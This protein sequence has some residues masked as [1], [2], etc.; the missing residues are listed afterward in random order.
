MKSWGVSLKNLMLPG[1]NHAGSTAVEMGITML[2]FLLA[3]FGIIEFGWYFLKVHTTNSAVSQGV[4]VGATGAVL[5]DGNGNMLSRE[6]SIKKAI[7]D[8]TKGLVT[9]DPNDI[10][11]FQVN[12]NFTDPTDPAVLNTANGGASGAFMRVR[13]THDH[14]FFNKLIGGFF[15]GNKTTITSESTY[16]NENFVLGGP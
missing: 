2:P 13:V 15:A 10:K 8:R 1:R 5:D 14:Q 3:V 16:R 9:I 12:A 4:R 11:I 6:E 7:L